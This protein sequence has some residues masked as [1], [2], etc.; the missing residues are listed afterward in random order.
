M[1]ERVKHWVE[2]EN[3]SSCECCP[4]YRYVVQSNKADSLFVSFSAEEADAECDRLK[5]LQEGLP[6]KPPVTYTKAQNDLSR[7]IIDKILAERK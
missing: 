2:Q 7:E 1:K 6:Q 5:N 4:S 3:V